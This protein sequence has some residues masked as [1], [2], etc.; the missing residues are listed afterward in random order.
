MDRI[1]VHGDRYVGTKFADSASFDEKN[2]DMED[3]F[4]SGRC[5]I[6]RP[7]GANYRHDVEYEFLNIHACKS[8]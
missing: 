2:I 4:A 3:E 5:F 6:L 7:G 1:A 8:N